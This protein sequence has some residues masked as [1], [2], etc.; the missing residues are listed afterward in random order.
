MKERI[1]IIEDDPFLREMY[2]KRLELEG[3][4]VLVAVAGDEGLKKI[5]EE[6][7]HLV[8]LDI[9]LP[10]TSGFE[11]LQKLNEN[12]D[13]KNIPII[14]LTSLEDTAKIEKGMGLGA[15]DYLSKSRFMPNTVVKKVK[16]TLAT[17]QTK[18]LPA[19]H[20]QIKETMNDAPR[21]AHDFRFRRLFKCPF[22][23]TDLRLELI[24]DRT[25]EPGTW[26]SAHF[27]CTK[28]KK[29]F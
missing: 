17:W 28:C 23:D 13:Y 20:L 12:P 29:E 11:I 9:M 10:S 2:Q 5:L 24:P 21:L 15:I 27:V 18:F 7:P 14:L 8:L 22:C 1:L 25:K 4:E 26:F 6:R 16:E 3:Y 19:Y